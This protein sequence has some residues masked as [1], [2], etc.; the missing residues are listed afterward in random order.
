MIAG[1]GAE[2][3]C[4]KRLKDSPSGHP[5]AAGKSQEADGWASRLLL[6]T[7]GSLARGEDN[8]EPGLAAEH[9]VVGL[10]DAVQREDF[11]H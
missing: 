6:M 9:A 11:V 7:F 10:V 2:F 1:Y 5:P 3:N 4:E 8:S